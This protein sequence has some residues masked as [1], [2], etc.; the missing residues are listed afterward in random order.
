MFARAHT[1]Y[2]LRDDKFGDRSISFKIRQ[3]MM[4]KRDRT[5]EEPLI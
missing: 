2:K 4:R 1:A 5:Y 3:F